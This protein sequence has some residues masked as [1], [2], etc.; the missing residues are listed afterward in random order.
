MDCGRLVDVTLSFGVADPAPQGPA[1]QVANAALAAVHA[2][3][4]GTRRETFVEGAS[5]E[6]SWHLS[7]LGELDAAMAEGRLWNAYQ[8]K[9]DLATGRIVGVEA[10]VRWDH[11]ERGLI[12][13]DGFIPMLEEHGRARDLTL[14]VL[15]RALDPNEIA[16]AV[17]LEA[18]ETPPETAVREVREEAGGP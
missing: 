6:T 3:R 18:G 10:L 16:A 12:A 7:L 11:P 9:L 5:D 17:D 2:A 15:D 14:H 4:R 13:P 1:Q 8:P